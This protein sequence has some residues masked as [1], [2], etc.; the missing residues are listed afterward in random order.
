MNY[1]IFSVKQKWE[2]E[3]LYKA[4]EIYRQRM[5]DQFWGISLHTPNRSN[6]A[7]N[8]KVIFYLG[9]PDMQ[10]AGTAAIRG[11][12]T[13]KNQSEFENL[14]HGTSEVYRYNTGV[15]LED[16]Q[17]WDEQQDFNALIHELSFIENKKNWGIYLQGGVTRIPKEDYIFIL[18]NSP[19][20]G[21]HEKKKNFLQTL[22]WRFKKLWYNVQGKIKKSFGKKTKLNKQRSSYASQVIGKSAP[23]ALE[24]IDQE[25]DQL[26]SDGVNK[27]TT[28]PSIKKEIT[29]QPV[30]D[31]EDLGLPDTP[32]LESSLEDIDPVKAGVS[33]P[34]KSSS[35]VPYK[36]S[37][38]TENEIHAVN[39]Q[40][41][42]ETS[43]MEM[44]DFSDN[45]SSP[46]EN[47]AQ[48]E[49]FIEDE[50]MTPELNP[51]QEVEGDEENIQ[52]ESTPEDLFIE[53]E[54]D[55]EETTDYFEQA[56]G[57]SHDEESF[58]EPLDEGFPVLDGKT[59]SIKSNTT[60]RTPQ[61]RREKREWK[62]GR[63]YKTHR[64]NRM[65][66]IHLTDDQVDEFIQD[67]S[68]NETKLLTSMSLLSLENYFYETLKRV[69]LIG[70]LPISRGLFIHLCDLVRDDPTKRRRVPNEVP[71]SLYIILM[72]FCARYSG[73]ESRKF[74]EPY[75]RIVWECDGTEQYFQ[76][77]C[78]NHFIACRQDLEESTG[79]YFRVDRLGDAVLPI[80][81]H[82]IIPFHLMDN[83]A[84]WIVQ[85][86]EL[87][88]SNKSVQMR[89]LFGLVAKTTN[90]PQR[91][92]RFIT[93]K[94]TAQSAVDL[95]QKM[96]DAIKLFRETG[97]PDL[98]EKLIDTPIEKSVWNAIYNYLT[99]EPDKVAKLTQV[100]P[101]LDWVWLVDEEDLAL[102]LSRVQS[103]LDQKPN[104][105]YVSSQLNFKNASYCP[106]LSPWK[107]P[108]K[109][110]SLDKLRIPSEKLIDKEEIFIV[111]NHYELDQ[112]PNAQNDNVI[113]S[114]P[115]PEIDEALLVFRVSQYRMM[116]VQKDK[117]D[118][119]GNWVVLAKSDV[120]VISSDGS[121]VISDRLNIPHFLRL[122]GFVFAGKFQIDLPIRIILGGEENQISEPVDT[123]IIELSSISGEG[124]IPDLSEFIP[125]V[126]Q[127]NQ[128]VLSLTLNQQLK[129]RNTWLTLSK[130]RSERETLSFTELN[131][132]GL[133]SQQGEEIILSL[134]H[135][136]MNSGLYQIDVLKGLRSLLDEPIEFGYLSN[137]QVVPPSLN[138][139]FSPQDNPLQVVV[140]GAEE[141]EFILPEDSKIR[142]S[143]EFQVVSWKLHKESECGF[144]IANHYGDHLSFSWRIDRVSSWIDGGFNKNLVKQGQESHVILNVRGRQRQE[145]CWTIEPDTK[146][147]FSLDNKG[148]FSTKLNETQLRDLLR[149]QTTVKSLV[150]IE[151]GGLQWNVFHYLKIPN[152][153]IVKVKYENGEVKYEV[154]QSEVLEG[155][156]HL[157]IN[158]RGIGAPVK[159]KQQNRLDSINSW[160]VDL[161]DGYY[162]LEILLEN[163]RLV[164][165]DEFMC[166]TIQP[167]PKPKPP[168]KIPTKTEVKAPS[169][170]EIY[171]LVTSDYA[172]LDSNTD[173]SNFNLPPLN[174]ILKINDRDTWY[175]EGKVDEGI[176]KLLPFWAVT[177]YPLRFVEQKFHKTLIIYPEEAAFGGIVGRGYSY[178]K[179]RDQRE[180]VYAAWKPDGGEGHI[181][182]FLCFRDSQIPAVFFKKNEVASW[183][184]HNLRPAYQCID[185]GELLGSGEGGFPP[186]I[187]NKHLHGEQRRA[188]EQFVDIRHRESLDNTI[189]LYQDETLD[190]SRS[191]KNN[192]NQVRGYLALLEKQP[193]LKR[194]GTLSLP[195][196][197][198]SNL[199]Y[200]KAVTEL[201]N[202]KSQADKRESI[203]GF[204]DV[205]DGFQKVESYYREHEERL[206]QFAILLRLAEGL[207]EED[208][209]G[210]IPEKVLYYCMLLRLKANLPNEFNQLLEVTGIN[211]DELVRLL[212]LGQVGFPKLIEW[213]MAWSEI[214]FVHALS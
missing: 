202:N 194:E 87:F 4:E 114:T 121:Q 131:K 207:K 110:W 62:A 127:S 115:I 23:S 140:K 209:L 104:T 78:R 116:A 138:Q 9:A 89:D 148:E 8:D 191:V 94:D 150:D 73:V 182:L 185:C 106:S 13:P 189:T 72:V 175:I 132:M 107:S 160:R 193:K 50:I 71:P 196:E 190:Y 69:Q 123:S 126:F 199:D 211:Q 177:K 143:N 63:Y 52:T 32:T 205:F 80:Y 24:P 168:I 108:G 188:F 95:V 25:Q 156:F 130:P 109:G 66:F 118:R 134:S 135:F 152:I 74:W 142:R 68:E 163:S 35:T 57:C 208:P 214:F 67:L 39:G 112:P 27:T 184:L 129:F 101:K 48:E 31:I 53:S 12:L 195:I 144:S 56:D 153:A 133:I 198:E 47:E 96:L 21:V 77:Q 40:G 30:V 91:L 173:E 186:D 162:C 103:T 164:L 176:K 81:Q 159:E 213:G 7:T 18:Q 64:L 88:L 183:P 58:Q 119:S 45:T 75:G 165:S 60:K 204:L 82:T 36:E 151:I 178:L 166:R 171:N 59:P 76:H 174:Q 212:K 179:V 139:V 192:F 113:F 120:Q 86:F 85:H 1:W 157:F 49:P 2:G 6:F 17:I 100:K 136:L 20:G 3:R 33:Q 92:I 43:T 137:T 158:K 210:Q 14:A 206:I 170:E 201:F 10:L 34:D 125:P 83:F 51:S 180:K 19:D 122:N 42:N 146:L 117:I 46:L 29:D 84:E 172:K 22:W 44:G 38:V 37:A 111:S 55:R 149:A 61:L 141:W 187:F 128:V 41:T 98:V 147:S 65:R 93:D 79:L 11:I 26:M 181:K 90:I 167:N 155:N 28:L 102:C 200:A 16:I 99:E 5:Q 97:H 197:T 169:I 105:L 54:S 161:D 203:D 145:A 154:E 70:E 15:W 124:P